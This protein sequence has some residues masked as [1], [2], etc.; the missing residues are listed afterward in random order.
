M[1]ART[2]QAEKRPVGFL[3]SSGFFIL[4]TGSRSTE[5]DDLLRPKS[6]ARCLSSFRQINNARVFARPSV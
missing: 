1:E 5:C 2:A 3:Q 4:P 6:A